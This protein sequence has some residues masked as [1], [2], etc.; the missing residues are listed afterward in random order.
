MQHFANTH[1]RIM[2]AALIFINAVLGVLIVYFIV[3]GDDTDVAD[4]AEIENNEP[5]ISEDSG[6]GTIIVTT[7]PEN[8]DLVGGDLVLTTI[9][10]YLAFCDGD[11]D[12]TFESEDELI[13]SI[14]ESPEPLGSLDYDN[15]TYG[16]A[17]KIVAFVRDV[18]RSVTPP[19]EVQEYHDIITDFFALTHDVIKTQDQNA[20]VNE[21]VLEVLGEEFL[22]DNPDILTNTIQLGLRLNRWREDTPQELLDRMIVADCPLVSSDSDS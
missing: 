1:F 20:Y 15:I 3:Q 22:L 21:E 19:D 16:Q 11:I 17:A 12:H 4:I 7:E 13:Q 6:N 5:V 14:L 18:F 10:E 8:S 9:D 2:I